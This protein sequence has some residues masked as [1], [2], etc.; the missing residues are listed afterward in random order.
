MRWSQCIAAAWYGDRTWI[1]A[2]WPL[3]LAYRGA[4]R[5]HR[6]RGQVQA[7]A[8]IKRHGRLAAPVVVIGNITAGGTGKTPLLLHL[9]ARLRSAG[10]RVGA[11]ARGYGG[12]ARHY[13]HRVCAADS[14]QTVGDEPL[15]IAQYGLPIVIDPDRYAAAKHLLCQTSV[16][17]ILSDDGLQHH[18]LPRALEIL[19]VDG[20][21]QFGNGMLLPAGPL[22]EPLARLHQVD[23]CL[24]NGA[25]DNDD[26]GDNSGAGDEN[27]NPLHPELARALDGHFHLQPRHWLQLAPNTQ[28]AIDALPAARTVHAIA[29]IG[30]PQ[31]F[32]ATLASLGLR[33]HHCHPLADHAPISA[34][35][36]RRLGANDPATQILM[37]TKD[38]V[39]CRQTIAAHDWRNCWALEVGVTMQAELENRLLAAIK[40]TLTTRRGT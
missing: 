38:A 33:P 6:R 22:R 3:T 2:L 9:A 11:I 13:P 31:R 35:H 4:L 17:L 26:S 14:P 28:I 39:K 20:Q 8:Q 36:L 21:R 19:V 7:Q 5:Q 24:L 25:P 23:F 34:E 30:N 40:A 12:R 27:D 18:A 32:F 37:T 16:D 29:A 1:R 15:L 10:I